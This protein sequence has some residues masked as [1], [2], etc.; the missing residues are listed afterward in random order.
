MI[1]SYEILTKSL[2]VF[3][4]KCS[5]SK[6]IKAE[7]YLEFR[8]SLWAERIPNLGLSAK[9]GCKSWPTRELVPP[10]KISS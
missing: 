4:A 8:L 9:D 5:T 6:L 2:L 3:E 10:N 1:I 7:N